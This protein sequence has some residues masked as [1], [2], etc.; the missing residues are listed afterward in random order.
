MKS[1]PLRRSLHR[2]E[3]PI[4]SAPE[5]IEQFHQETTVKYPTFQPQPV[6]APIPYTPEII[7]KLAQAHDAIPVRHHYHHDDMDQ[8]QAFSASGGLNQQPGGSYRNPQPPTP[9]PSPPPQL[10]PKKQQYQ[11]D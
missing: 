7:S 9:A 6:Q 5:D 8:Q 3:M 1:S 4:K 2:A 11:T 10:K